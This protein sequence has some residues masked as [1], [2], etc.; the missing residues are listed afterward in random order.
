MISRHSDQPPLFKKHP[1]G[2]I[3]VLPKIIDDFILKQK[4]RLDIRKIDDLVAYDH[5]T[6]N[7]PV[8]V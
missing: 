3:N 8:L 5:T 7:T 6:M 1:C 2:R 4:D